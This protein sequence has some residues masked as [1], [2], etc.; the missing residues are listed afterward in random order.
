MTKLKNYIKPKSESK[1][2]D[3]CLDTLEPIHRAAICYKFGIGG[4]KPMTYKEIGKVMG[5]HIMWMPYR[6]FTGPAARMW[7]LKGL[8]V[9]QRKSRAKHLI[10]VLE[11]YKEKDRKRSCVVPKGKAPYY[12]MNEYHG[13]GENEF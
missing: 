4:T 10:D 5:N 1:I 11:M 9:L 13:Y 12:A 6:P 2:L 8:E 7:V 3:Y